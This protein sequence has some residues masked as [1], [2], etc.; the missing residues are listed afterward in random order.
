MPVANDV[1]GYFQLG[2]KLRCFTLEVMDYE[3][4]IAK[5]DSSGNGS[6]QRMLEEFMRGLCYTVDA[7]GNSYVWEFSCANFGPNS[8]TSK[9]DNDFDNQADSSGTGSGHKMLEK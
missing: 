7:S 5:L 2:L 4:Y 8:L 3:I 1:T 9:G 6:G